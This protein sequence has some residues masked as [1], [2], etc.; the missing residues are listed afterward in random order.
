MPLASEG[1]GEGPIETHAPLTPVAAWLTAYAVRIRT[2][3]WIARFRSAAEFAPGMRRPFICHSSRA[4]TCRRPW[5]ACVCTA[6]CCPCRALVIAMAMYA[7]ATAADRLRILFAASFVMGQYGHAVLLTGG[8]ADIFP[9]C[10][11]RAMI[12][13]TVRL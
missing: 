11:S 5:T 12:E 9:R 10:T 13:P 7:S 3:C 2:F 6:G 1:R 4:R 8:A